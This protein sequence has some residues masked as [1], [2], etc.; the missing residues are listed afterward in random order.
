[1]ASDLEE[2]ARGIEAQLAELR[3]HVARLESGEMK[4]GSNDGTGWKDTTAETI[5]FDRNT[6]ATYE[7]ILTDVRSRIEQGS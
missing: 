3:E 7:A 1:M 6:I 2:Y 4:L 5:D